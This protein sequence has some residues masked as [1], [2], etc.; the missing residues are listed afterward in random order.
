MFT[1]YIN[2]S[3]S[4]LVPGPVTDITIEATEYTVFLTWNFPLPIVGDYDY[5]AAYNNISLLSNINS[6][7]IESLAPG[8]EYQF[9][10]S[11]FCFIIS[12]VA[13]KTS[14]PNQ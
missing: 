14:C 6:I 4:I 3:D 9:K 2:M 11:K 5:I 13:K 8:T 12:V 7:L 1:Y 10:V